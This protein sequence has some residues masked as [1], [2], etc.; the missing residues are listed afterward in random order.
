MTVRHAI[1]LLLRSGLASA[2]HGRR[3]VFVAGPDHAGSPTRHLSPDDLLALV[4]V[5]EHI[6]GHVLTTEQ[7]SA[8]QSVYRAARARHKGGQGRQ[9]GPKALSK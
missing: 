5:V 6:N 2:E 3:G 1:Q 9:G 4:A 7:Y 8:L